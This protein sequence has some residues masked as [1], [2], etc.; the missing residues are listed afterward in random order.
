MGSVVIDEN[1]QPLLLAEV[2][3]ANWLLENKI[4][5]S[6]DEDDED[7]ED[8]KTRVWIET[9]KLWHIVGPA[10]FSRIGTYSMNIITQG[11]AGHLGEVELAAISISNTVIVGLSFGLILGMASAL[12]TLCGQA[13]G[14][15]KHHMIGIYMQRSWIVITI[16]CILLLPMYIF[17]TPI[18]KALGQPNDVAELS[19]VVA[20]WFIPLQFSFAFQFTIQRFL[21]SQLKTAV[22]AWIS[23]AVL[24]IHTAISWLFVYK[25]KLGIVGAAVALDISWWLLVVGLFI[26]AACGGCPETWNGF[27]TQ[28]FSGLWEFFRLSASAGVM[29]C[30]ENW[31]YRILI[32]MAGYLQNATLTVDA[33]SICMNI[34]SWEMMIPLAFIAATGIR[35]ANE[36]GAGRGNAA[37]FA[38]VISVIYSTMIGLVFC[39]LVMIF[40]QKF[41]LFFSSNFDVLKFVNK[42]SYLLALT[43]LLNSIQPVLSGVAVGSGW[44]LKVAYINLGCYYIVGV[45][46]GIVMGMVLHNGLEGLWAGMIFGGT[47]LQTI[48]L[49]FITYRS[50]WEGEARKARMHVE[51]WSEPPPVS[52][53]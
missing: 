4:K 39:I 52:Q 48:I 5:R 22:I 27:S 1:R 20:L 42:I 43:I 11:F 15:K 46:L 51:K 7:D 24:A 28:A 18:L 30:L 8:L 3:S 13:Y 33:L 21:Q 12:E 16:C 37:K 2:I 31:Y 9:K 45:P 35:V 32:L 50:D 17:A 53:S 40:Q 41:A 25:L 23:L 34:N 44:Q 36:L 10:I 38:A 6:E 47:A 14:A 29:L 26:Y 49:A 19:G